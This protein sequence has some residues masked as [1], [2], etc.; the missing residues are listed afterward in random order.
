LGFWANY[1]GVQNDFNSPVRVRAY[2][3]TPYLA[4]RYFDLQDTQSAK[5]LAQI[6]EEDFQA[7]ASGSKTRDPRDEKLSK[8]HEEIDK[9]WGEICYKLDALSSLNFV[10]KQPKAQITT[11]DNLPTT[12]MES[13][14]PPTSAATTLLAP[15]ELFRPPTSSNLVSRSELTPEQAQAARSKR[16]REKKGDRKRLGDMAELYAKKKGGVKGEKERALQGLVKS[17]KGVT[18]VGKGDKEAGK[19]RKRAMGQDGTERHDGKRL[20]L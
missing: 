4:S 5:S 19:A 9:L 17:G 14:L 13:A 16:K 7:A 6:Y 2:E 8:E 12:T 15:E 10:P 3:P 20:K 1:P 18:V 11:V